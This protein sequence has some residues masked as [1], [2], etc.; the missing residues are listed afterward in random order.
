MSLSN[1]LGSFLTLALVL[2]DLRPTLVPPTFVFG[3][4]LWPVLR[5][6]LTGGA[7]G[8]PLSPNLPL[9]FRG[10]LKEHNCRLLVWI[11]GR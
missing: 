1:L 3:A 2:H 7:C 11:T 10:S 8:S 9:L 6:S 4:A 5:L